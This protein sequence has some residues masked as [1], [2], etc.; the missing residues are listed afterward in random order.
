MWGKNA[1]FDALSV[2]NF[3]ITCKTQSNLIENANWLFL[4][5][6]YAFGRPN[7]VQDLKGFC[8]GHN[9][10]CEAHFPSLVLEPVTRGKTLLIIHS[11]KLIPD[12]NI[13][14]LD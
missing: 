4:L 10:I 5:Y 11:S 3:K 13:N 14:P 7:V 6:D 1:R 8:C 12:I 9:I 2:N